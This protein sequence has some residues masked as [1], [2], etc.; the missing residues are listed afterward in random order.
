MA[1]GLL[2]KKIGMS[3]TFDQIG[4]MIPVTVIEL[5]P[6]TV[7]Q[8]KTV[9][10]KDGYNA[11]KLGF[12]T[13][14]ITRINKPELAVFKNAGVEPAAFTREFRVDA[15]F[16]ADYNVGDEMGVTM[17]QPGEKVDVTGI[18]KGHGY[19]GVVKRHGFK[20]AKEATHGTHEYQRHSGSIGM[21]ADPGRVI[22]GKRM[23]GQMGNDRVTVRGLT[24]VAV[25]PEENVLMVKGGIPGARNG[26][27]EVRVSANQPATI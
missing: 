7:I 6:N 5:G 8:V 21:S 26:I 19:Q 17:F 18:S 2:G 20:G 23:P 22:K 3:Q 24:I 25:H 11:I 9:D 14:K 15:E 10:G 27:V 1:R 12:G 13:K 16:I 4:N